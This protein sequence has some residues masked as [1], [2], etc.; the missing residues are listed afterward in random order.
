MSEELA[1]QR[2]M[3][4]TLKATASQQEKSAKENEVKNQE[5]IAQLKQEAAEND[6]K[7]AATIL[8]LKNEMNTNHREE[9]KV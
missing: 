6:E 8:Q 5:T 3:I 2:E 9:S 7:S 1:N 4:E